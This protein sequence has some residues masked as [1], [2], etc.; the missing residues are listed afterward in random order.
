[1]A[2]AV[3]PVVGHQASYT[4]NGFS[5]RILIIEDDVLVP[6]VL[7]ALLPGAAF[8]VVPGRGAPAA[9]SALP[10]PPDLILVDN[11]LL[12]GTG[13]AIVAAVRRAAP[14]CPLVL[15]TADATM[16][17]AT[18]RAAGADAWAWRG[19]DGQA[20]WQRLQMAIHVAAVQHAHAGLRRWIHGVDH[21][22]AQQARRPDRRTL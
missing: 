7:Q 14:S 17:G 6:D 10:G 12:S 11:G 9:I 2:C 15:V 13:V 8:T 18:A 3:P 20:L 4:E 1:M 22:L 21:A 16:D 19:E 5:P